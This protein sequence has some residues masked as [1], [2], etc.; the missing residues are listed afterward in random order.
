MKNKNKIFS[1]AVTFALCGVFTFTACN[2]IK[3]FTGGTDSYDWVRAVIDEYYYKD[4]PDD[5]EYTGDLHAFVSQ[6]LDAYSA[7][8][9]KEEYEAVYASNQGSKSG[10]GISYMYVDSGIYGDESGLVVERVIGNSP[11]Y[12]SGL[13]AGEVI[14][15]ITCGGEET[16]ITY[17][18]QFS[19]I[20]SQI[21][22][23][24]SFTF[25]TDKGEYTLAK[26]EYTASYCTMSTSDKSWN[27][28]YEGS[29]RTINETEGGIDC[30]PEGAAYLRLDQFYGN[31]GYEMAELI[32]E[33]NA[34]GCTSLILDLRGNGGGYVALMQQMAAIFVTEREGH[35][36]VAM[37]SVYKNGNKE[38]FAVN[39]TFMD[40][41]NVENWTLGA[42]VKV[43]VLA[44]NGTAS[45]SEA[46]IGVLMS[47]GVISSGDIY[48]SD[49][50]ENYLTRTKTTAKNCRTYGKGIMQSTYTRVDRLTGTLECALKLTTATIYWPDGETCIHDKGITGTSVYTDWDVTYGDTQ[51][52]DIV[53]LIYG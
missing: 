6:Y 32:S 2:K 41:K 21:P 17:D 43:S 36:D 44:D 9:T 46:L 49:L 18:G 42:D 53:K 12:Y 37:Y 33:F 13:K 29:T 24:E 14:Q 1:A 26:A 38:S 15:F 8:Y 28:S 40:G 20:L 31:A 5:C 22:D 3:V 52:S 45:A 23:G 51:L 35:S 34:E 19:E 10:V 7:Y 25:T 50:S 11:A 47:A 27:I 48:V 30:L 39:Y 16:R 4:L